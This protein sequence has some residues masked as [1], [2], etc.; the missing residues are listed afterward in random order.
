MTEIDEQADKQK[1]KDQQKNYINW[2]REFFIS[3]GASDKETCEVIETRDWS[4]AAM[5]R[6]VDDHFD[7]WLYRQ[8]EDEEITQWG[9]ASHLEWTTH[10]GVC[11]NESRIIDM[12]TGG[13]YYGAIDPVYYSDKQVSCFQCIKI[14]TADDVKEF[15]YRSAICPFCGYDTIIPGRQYRGVEITLRHLQQMHDF[16][17]VKHKYDWH[18][19]LYERD[20]KESREKSEEESEDKKI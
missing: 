9:T 15:K 5:H 11:T 2:V 4:F 7:W 12:Q 17:F 19:S 10:E 6:N 1:E 13:K 8:H 20:K 18:G 14:F 16:W 3:H